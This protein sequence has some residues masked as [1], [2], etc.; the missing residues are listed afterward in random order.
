M[1][2]RETYDSKCLVVVYGLARCWTNRRSD[3]KMAWV[4]LIVKLH[5]H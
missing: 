4:W 1:Y 3:I 5:Y 2:F